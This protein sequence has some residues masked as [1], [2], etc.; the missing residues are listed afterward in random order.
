MGR[1][2]RRRE[3]E[4]QLVE[5]QTYFERSRVGRLVAWWSRLRGHARLWPGPTRPLGTLTNDDI[6]RMEE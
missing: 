3:R 4:R 6:D 1:R 2:G 5:A